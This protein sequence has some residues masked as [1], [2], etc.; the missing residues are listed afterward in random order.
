MSAGPG[1]VV[2]YVMESQVDNLPWFCEERTHDDEQA[3]AWAPWLEDF[4]RVHQLT[5]VRLARE[6]RNTDGELVAKS[7]LRETQ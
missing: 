7:I 1:L 4:C 6:V 2:T 5:R 3:R